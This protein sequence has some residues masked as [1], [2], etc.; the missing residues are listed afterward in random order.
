MDFARPPRLGTIIRF[1]AWYNHMVSGLKQ[2][3]FKV[4]ENDPCLYVHKTMIAVSWVDDVIVATANDA[5]IYALVDR[6]RQRGYELDVESELSAYLGLDI[7][8]IL[9]EHGT[10]VTGQKSGCWVCHN[11]GWSHSQGH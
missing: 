9:D 4:S 5:D 7:N 11:P 8:P 3:G 6:L 2:E 1:L 10:P